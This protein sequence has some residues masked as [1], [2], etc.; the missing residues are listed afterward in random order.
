MTASIM[1]TPNAG[2]DMADFFDFGEAAMPDVQQDYDLDVS[3]AQPN[4]E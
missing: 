3:A 4:Q 1:V 2:S